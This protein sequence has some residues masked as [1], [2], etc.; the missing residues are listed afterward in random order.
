[1]RMPNYLVHQRV[2]LRRQCFVHLDQ[3]RLR[4]LISELVFCSVIERFEVIRKLRH[5]VNSI[6]QKQWR[7]SP[8]KHWGIPCSLPIDYT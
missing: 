2:L 5:H 7:I 8:K 1:M 4:H 3:D 6:V